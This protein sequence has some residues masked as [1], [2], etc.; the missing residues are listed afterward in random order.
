MARLNL[1]EESHGELLMVDDKDIEPLST[2][3]WDK[4]FSLFRR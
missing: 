1:T 2:N 3:A 4:G